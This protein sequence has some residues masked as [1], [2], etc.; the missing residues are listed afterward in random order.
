MLPGVF[1]RFLSFSVLLA[2]TGACSEDGSRGE[3]TAP[4][5]GGSSSGSDS[6]GGAPTGSSGP[7]PTSSDT[8]GA[9]DTSGGTSEAGD[10]TSTSDT[11]T[12]GE[13]LPVGRVEI[14]FWCGPPAE[15]LTAE[16]FA[17][18]A[19]AGFTFVAN[20]CDSATHNPEYNTAM[21]ALA[22][23]AGLGGFV[24]DERALAAAV[25]QDVD[26]NLDAVVADYGG[27]PALLGYH[28][29]DEPRSDRFPDLGAAVGGLRDRDPGHPGIVNLLP[30][31]ASVDQLGE[32]SYDAYI[33]AFL[34]AVQPANYSYDH[35]NFLNDGTDGPTFFAN[36]E[37][38]RAH[39]V[40]AGVPF[41]VY[42]QAISYN[43]HRATTGPEKR[44]AALHTL[45]Y[46]G[47][48]VMYFT[49]WTP[50]QTQENFG[51]GIIAA[52]GQP[53]AQYA[54]VTAINRTLA[55]MGRYLGA[56]TSTGVFHNG[57]L[58]AGVVPRPPAAPVYVPGPA[59]VSV[60]LFAVGDGA[61][62]LLVNRDHDAPTST[63]VYLTAAGTPT[64]MN[65]ATGEL[66]PAPGAV[67]DAIGTR[68]HLELAA[69]DGALFHLP[70]P[71]PAGPPGAEAYVG[72][73]RADLG[74]LDVVDAAFGAQRLRAAAWDE[75][76][77]GTTNV[78]HLFAS[79]GFWLCARDDL[80]GRG[81]YVGNVVQDVGNLLRV[82]A[83]VVTPVGMA[84][85]DTC[86]DGT[87]LGHR[88]ASDGFW[89]CMAP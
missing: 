84:A 8:T 70:G 4:V 36:L 72:T 60:G 85:W 64:Q 9:P 13:A 22:Q 6:S 66:E 37:V 61:Y 88:F 32:P 57:P 69:G 58:A 76:P 19:A 2:M 78:G 80:A 12:G 3:G 29:Y 15:E 17:Q 18:I 28:L 51:D 47:T 31:Y 25:G 39:S 49:Y 45:A 82:E 53:T 5:S 20:A 55:V 67:Q 81:F 27:H 35:Y 65:P 43:G 42:I 73:V 41:G 1:A 14:G 63:D 16:R 30:D 79:D 59:P 86:P 44:W 24:S 77:A 62:A 52:D 11:D 23:A 40:A 21:L 50:P 83:G 75:C 38:V 71:V 46:G 89:L 54:D 87:L 10:T 48:T 34:A 26:A 56:A 7:V 33:A 74:A 68:V